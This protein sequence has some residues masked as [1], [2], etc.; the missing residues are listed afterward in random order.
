MAVIDA[1]TETA[2]GFG[3]WS[4]SAGVGRLNHVGGLFVYTLCDMVGVSF[5]QNLGNFEVSDYII[6]QTLVRDFDAIL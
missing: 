6:L 4:R 5:G 2:S 3:S 1:V